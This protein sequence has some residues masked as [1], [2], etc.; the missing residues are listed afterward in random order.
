MSQYATSQGILTDE[1]SAPAGLPHMVTQGNLID[2]TRITTEYMLT[3]LDDEYEGMLIPKNS[4]VFIGIW[5]MHH[6]K[7]SYSN[8]DDFNPDRYLDHPKLA[9][10]YAVSPDYKNRDKF[11][12]SFRK[13]P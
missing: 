9:N 7:D 8:Y 3:A 6:S 5:A 12:P 4:M 10:E 11:G 13:G 1:N 2:S